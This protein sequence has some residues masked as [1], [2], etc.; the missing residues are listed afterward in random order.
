M[1]TH[2]ILSIFFLLYLPCALVAMETNEDPSSS[3]NNSSDQST[4]SASPMQLKKA[5][6]NSG[7]NSSDE[8]MEKKF[9]A[10]ALERK[11]SPSAMLKTK[12]KS[13]TDLRRLRELQRSQTQ[14]SSKRKLER[15]QSTYE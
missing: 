3:G 15:S 1:K 11:Q 6:K 8:A 4:P 12:Q 13:E 7:Y 2:F 9:P 10:L 5:F 14:Q